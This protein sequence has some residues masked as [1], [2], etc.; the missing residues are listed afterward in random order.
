MINE[1]D[2]SKR[3]EAALL[4]HGFEAPKGFFSELG[5]EQLTAIGVAIILE[6]IDGVMK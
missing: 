3:L 2:P 5:I 6:K 4:L 1:K